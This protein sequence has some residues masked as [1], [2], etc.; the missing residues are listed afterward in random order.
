MPQ[1]GCEACGGLFFYEPDPKRWP[2]VC[3][4]CGNSDALQAWAGSRQ[5]ETEKSNIWHHGSPWPQRQ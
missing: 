4:Q 2:P 5:W 3:P 1:L